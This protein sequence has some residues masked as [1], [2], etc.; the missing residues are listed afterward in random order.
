[1][2]AAKL[3]VLLIL[4][5]IVLAAVAVFS[6]PASAP[7]AASTASARGLCFNRGESY[8]FF[9]GTSS[10]DCREVT[11]RASA[12]LTAK[13]A[14]SDVCGEATVYKNFNLEKFLLQYGAKVVWREKLS[15]SVNYYCAANLP[16]SVN[17][18]GQTINLHVSVRGDTAKV[19][20]PII[21]GGY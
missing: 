15:D 21:F 19:G 14:L 4:S 12:A 8:T 3:S 20:S 5:C 17:L 7:A 10:A 1:M 9:C 16:Y 2:K 13:L 6:L 11:V 18:Y